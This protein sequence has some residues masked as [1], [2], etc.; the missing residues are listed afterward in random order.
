MNKPEII[1]LISRE[2]AI[3]KKAATKFLEALVGK[4]H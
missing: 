1:E 2:A 4:I 3:T